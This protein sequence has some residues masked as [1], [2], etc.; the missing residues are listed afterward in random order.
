M[1]HERL[2]IYTPYIT[3]MCKMDGFQGFG[4]TTWIGGRHLGED[5][6]LTG[7]EITSVSKP[8]ANCRHIV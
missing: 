2:C 7:Q 4:E 8:S 3:R 6:D 5:M 1:I